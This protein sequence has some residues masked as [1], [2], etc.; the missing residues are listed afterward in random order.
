MRD[1]RIDPDFGPRPALP[2]SDRPEAQDARGREPGVSE[3]PSASP[4]GGAL[5]LLGVGLLLVA[6]LG[7]F[8]LWSRKAS[9]EKADREART[10]AVAQGPLVRVATVRREPAI[11]QVM[12][13]GEVH[14]WQQAT[15]YAKVSGYLKAMLVD[16]GD[17][18]RKGQLLGKL[19]SPDS[20]QQVAAAEVDQ[21]LKV[22]Q[23]DRALRLS[24]T[25]VVAAQDL[26]NAQAGRKVAAASLK[27]L[28]ALQAYEEL[29]APFAGVVTQRFADVGALLPAATGATQSAQPVVEVADLS[30][31]RVWTYLGQDD[32]AQVRVGD[33]ARVTFDPRPG[34]VRSATVARLAQSLDPR[35]RTMLTEV[36]LD[37]RDGTLYPGEFVHV[38]LTLRSRP[39]ALIPS[40]AL[41]VRSG[42]LFV[43]VIDGGRAHLRP[44]EVLA[45]EGRTLQVASGLAGGETI[46]VNAAG[47]LVDGGRVRIHAES[48]AS[49]AMRDVR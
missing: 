7:V 40:E 18:V 13:P 37:N 42:K 22:Q 44:I 29:R 1:V 27:R 6:A 17:R 16:K 2:W 26:E 43:A 47:E 34:E 36:V 14:A 38:E 33:A 20:D 12:L 5:Y 49:Q 15:L 30:R 19:E 10:I 31:V 4:S 41:I 11:R 48:G 3:G 46:A 21:R 24:M 45:D 32:A 35:T 9:S 8:S 39:A 23:E 25:G 28:L